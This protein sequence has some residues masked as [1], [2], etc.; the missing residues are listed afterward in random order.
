[1][2]IKMS[3]GQ[4]SSLTYCKKCHSPIEIYPNQES[5]ECKYCKEVNDL[6]LDTNLN[7]LNDKKDMRI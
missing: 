2:N 5:V 3:L 7:L 6:I 1:M 4:I